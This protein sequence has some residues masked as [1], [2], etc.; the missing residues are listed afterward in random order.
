MPSRLAL[1]AL[2]AAAAALLVPA[3]AAQAATTDVYA[4]PPPAKAK[5][6]PAGGLA[7]AFYPRAATVKKG[8]KVAFKFRGFHNVLFPAKGTTL[9]PLAAPDPSKPVTGVNDAAGA[10]M[11]FNGQPGIFVDP[12]N[13]I[14]Q[15]GQ[16]I[17]GKKLSGSGIFQGQGAP[18]D[19]VVSFPKKGTYGFYCT[20]H[21]GMEGKVKVVGK[22][23]KT[24][25]KAKQHRT[26]N[27]Q[28]KASVE[29][30]KQLAT[31]APAGNVVQ[32]GSDADEVA[33]LSFFPGTRAVT[34]GSAVEF[35]M[36]SDSTEIHNVVFGPTDYVNGLAESFFAPGPQGIALDAMSVYPSEPGPVTVNGTSHG[37]GFANTGVLDAD[38][39]SPFPASASVTFSTPGTYA[40]ICTV[41][42]PDMKG[43]IQVN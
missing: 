38:A 12:V 28:V 24:P 8:G 17:T 26:V 34:A 10:A 39:A 40:Y 35:K 30:A 18:P 5:D 23:G 25:S 32:A 36:S 21:P 22:G 7:N 31:V 9:G 19:Y 15:G 3:A 6:M 4:G 29:K 14:A 37:N 1:S 13:V 27:K 33:F 16:K 11:W 2:S 42:G 41:H 43:T 20:I